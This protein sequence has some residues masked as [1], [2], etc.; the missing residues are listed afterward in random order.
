MQ[1]TPVWSLGLE[2]PL[3]KGIATHSSILAWRIPW[4]EEPDTLQSMGSQGVGNNWVT[5][6]FTYIVFNLSHG[7]RSRYMNQSQTK[8]IL[9]PSGN[10]DLLNLSIGQSWT[11][12]SQW[13]SSHF[14]VWNRVSVIWNWRD[15]T[16]INYK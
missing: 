8:R 7:I 12:I 6:T 1:E 14:L 11:I 5:N 2:D 16:Q 10:H 13:M 3:E 15:P 9:Y 4:T